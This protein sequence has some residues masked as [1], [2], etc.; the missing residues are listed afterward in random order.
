MFFL[1]TS[2]VSGFASIVTAIKFRK[3]S[4][5]L[6]LPREISREGGGILYVYVY[7]TFTQTYI[8]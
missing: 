5:G 8:I 7:I 2:R 4:Q 6:S 3:I 1:A